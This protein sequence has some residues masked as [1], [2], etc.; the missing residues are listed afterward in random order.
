MRI[1][2]AIVGGTLIA[3]YVLSTVTLDPSGHIL[4]MLLFG[5]A[6]F[7]RRVIPQVTVRWDG[8]GMMVVALFAAVLTAHYFLR[9]L[10]RGMHRA[11][12]NTASAWRPRWTMTLA[13]F[14]LLMF[15]AGT[16]MIG[17]V[18]QAVWLAQ[19][20]Q[21]LYSKRLANSAT[22]EEK[23]RYIYMWADM[24]SQTRGGMPILDPQVQSG[25]GVPHSWVSQT[26]A[27]VQM[28][29]RVPWDQPPNLPLVR[30]VLPNVCNPSLDAPLKNKDGFGLNH[31][32]GNIHVFERSERLDPSTVQQGGANLLLIGEVNQDFVPWGQPH[33]S[34]D[35]RRGINKP[36]GFGGPPS[37]RRALVI[38]LDGSI[39]TL[40]E[41]IDSRVLESLAMPAAK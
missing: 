10:W 14:F 24:H 15:A 29:F 12:P 34:R 31:F 22:T 3:L 36:G 40:H 8:I 17:A 11:E 2:L 6:G 18:H 32:A 5:W 19:W 27:T 26:L 13:G 23:L 21:P 28:D 25:T 20:D 41:N 30:S 9:W 37:S 7:L 35:P 38:M 33:N 39:R 4:P 16:A 1:G